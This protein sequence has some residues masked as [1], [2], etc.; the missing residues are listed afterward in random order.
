MSVAPCDGMGVRR[1]LPTTL[2]RRSVLAKTGA[3]EVAEKHP[4]V[5]GHA[6]RVHERGIARAAYFCHAA[7]GI[8]FAA[9]GRTSQAVS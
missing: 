8:L 4:A 3:H 7:A 9:A 6:R 2:I 5:I 1:C